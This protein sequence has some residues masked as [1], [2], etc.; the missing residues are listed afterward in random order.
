[1]VVVHL[2]VVV[3]QHG[4]GAGRPPP[5][6]VRPG[7]RTRRARRALHLPLWADR[8]LFAPGSAAG[9]RRRLRLALDPC[10]R[11]RGGPVLLLGPAVELQQPLVV[12]GVALTPQ[13]KRLQTFGLGVQL[14]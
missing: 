4:E 3:P 5:P 9:R 6:V 1:M 8:A 10:R 11:R 13:N 7:L 12:A 14:V 2:R